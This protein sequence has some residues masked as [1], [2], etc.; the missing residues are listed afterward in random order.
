MPQVL[1]FSRPDQRSRKCADT[2]LPRCSFGSSVVLAVHLRC[3]SESNHAVN[4]Q[5]RYW[6]RRPAHFPRSYF[7]VQ[8]CAGGSFGRRSPFSAWRTPYKGE[9]CFQYGRRALEKRQPE[10]PIFYT[11]DASGMAADRSYNDFR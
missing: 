6:H 11:P 8:L 7:R 2:S 3:H 9:D 10:Q 1:I 5:M 4:Q